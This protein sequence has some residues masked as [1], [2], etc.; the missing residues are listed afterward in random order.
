[1]VRRLA[2]SHLAPTVVTAAIYMGCGASTPPAPPFAAYECTPEQ[3][4]AAATA[5][6]TQAEA[7]RRAEAASDETKAVVGGRWRMGCGGPAMEELLETT[8][9]VDAEY[10]VPLGEAG[11]IVPRWQALPETAKIGPRNA[12]RLRCWNESFALPVLVLSYPWLDRE[13]PDRLG[14]QLRKI[15]PILKAMLVQAKEYGE[16]ATIGVLWDYCSL[17]QKPLTRPR[18]RVR[19]S[20][21]PTRQFSRPPATW[22]SNRRRWQ[23][24]PPQS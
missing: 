20:A 23:C 19:A 9:L 12:W 17:P 11:G 22:R 6:A 16:H 7:H 18:Q 2:R 15:V 1:M 24:L 21:S 13:H 14:E 4:E 10:L 3:A 8:T 5:E